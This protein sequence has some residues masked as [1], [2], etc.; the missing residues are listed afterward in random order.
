MGHGGRLRP[1]QQ[2]KQPRCD[3]VVADRRYDT[4]GAF[5]D[6]RL[7]ARRGPIRGVDTDTGSTHPGDQCAIIGAPSADWVWGAGVALATSADPAR[8]IPAEK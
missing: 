2:A 6:R 7:A 4:R 3:H 8:T 1:S 5:G